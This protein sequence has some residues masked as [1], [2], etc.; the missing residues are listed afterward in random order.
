MW[1][2]NLGPLEEQLVLLTPEPSL[3]PPVLSCYTLLVKVS[4]STL[5]GLSV[6]TVEGK[7]KFDVRQLAYSYHTRRERQQTETER[8][9]L[10]L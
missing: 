2:L 3:Q 8:Q 7:M 4:A 6:S 5:K 9:R 10:G 1:V